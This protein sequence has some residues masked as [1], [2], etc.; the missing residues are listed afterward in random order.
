MSAAT[1]EVFQSALADFGYQ[2]ELQF[3]AAISLN[4]TRLLVHRKSEA[5]SALKMIVGM[6]KDTQPNNATAGWKFASN[7]RYCDQIETG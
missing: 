6:L 4:F 1:F 7:R 2:P 5:F 3:K